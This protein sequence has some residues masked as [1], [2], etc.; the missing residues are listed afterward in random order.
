MIVIINRK[1]SYGT[2]DGVITPNSQLFSLVNKHLKSATAKLQVDT[3][4]T[5]MYQLG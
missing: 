4:E 2:L 5:L 1:L 3:E